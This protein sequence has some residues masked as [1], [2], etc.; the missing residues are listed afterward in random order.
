M[1]DAR[2]RLII[3]GV[4]AIMLTVTAALLWGTG[5]AV[6]GELVGFVSAV[7]GFFAGTVYM[8]GSGGG[9]GGPGMRPKP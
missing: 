7:W 2:V 5:K 4:I 8:N 3:T 9:V 1:T 6:P